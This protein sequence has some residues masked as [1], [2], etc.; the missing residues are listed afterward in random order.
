MKVVNWIHYMMKETKSW[1]K[2]NDNHSVTTS[3][4]NCDV[5]AFLRPKQKLSWT[6]NKSTSKSSHSRIGFT[7]KGWKALGMAAQPALTW[8]TLQLITIPSIVIKVLQP[9]PG[10]SALC[11]L[12]AW[13]DAWKLNTLNWIESMTNLMTF[14]HLNE[15]LYIKKI[16]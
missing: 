4:G 5:T 12:D 11:W 7:L 9:G 10:W 1:Q 8:A 14:W 16:K 2:E 15:S 13:I 3:G 6:T